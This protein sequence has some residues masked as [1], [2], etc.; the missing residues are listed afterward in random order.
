MSHNT[1]SP[2]NP[3]AQVER[4]REII[5]GRQLARVEQRLDRLEQYAEKPRQPQQDA[6]YRIDLLEAQFEAT[7]DNVQQQVDQVRR[8]F[9]GEIANRQQ[10][11]HRLAEQIQLTAQSRNQN[12]GVGDINQ[13]LGQWQKSLE[14]HLEQRENWLIQQLRAELQQL[15]NQFDQKWQQ[16]EFQNHQPSP[17][18]QVKLQQL[19]DAARA[20]AE[21][22]ASLSVNPSFDVPTSTI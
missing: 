10:E 8:E 15:R 7:R 13:R 2:Y 5:V 20:L 11:V 3:S 14:S 1:P 18:S 22:A 21:S 17:Y 6:L 12:Q 9:G 19:A 16:W 4:M